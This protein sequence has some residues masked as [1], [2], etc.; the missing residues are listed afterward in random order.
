MEGVQERDKEMA[1]TIYEEQFLRLSTIS[2]FFFNESF[3]S[4]SKRVLKLVNLRLFRF[5]KLNLPGAPKVVRL[6]PNG[7]KLARSVSPFEVKQKRKVPL[8]TFEHDSVVSMTR[9]K[10]KEYF[11]ASWIPEKALKSHNLKKIPDGILLFQSG[12]RIAVEVENSV[13]SKDRYLEMWREWESHDF[14]LVLYVTT[15]D[16]VHKAIQKRMSEFPG[17]KVRFGLI[18]LN[19]LMEASAESVWTP[20]G[21]VALFGRR[22]F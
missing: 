12:R 1:K 19:V 8:S 5:E 20:K 21:S 10:L 18:H 14:L 7:V 22:S 17:T 3:Q 13:K 9:L 15:N 11:D 6:T 16:I 4:A 2:R